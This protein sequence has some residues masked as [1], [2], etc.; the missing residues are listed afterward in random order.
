MENILSPQDLKSLFYFLD[1]NTP[2]EITWLNNYIRKQGYDGYKYVHINGLISFLLQ[3]GL[4]KNSQSW[5]TFADK[6]KKAYRT[7]QTRKGENRKK[8]LNV[9][10]KPS[11]LKHLDTE[12]KKYEFS[13]SQFME[14][15]LNETIQDLMEIQEQ[16]HIDNEKRKNIEEDKRISILA[17][18]IRKKHT[19]INEL[20][21]ELD[22]VN[23]SLE[24]AQETLSYF[25]ETI[26]Q[27]AIINNE[28]DIQEICGLQTHYQNAMS[29]NIKQT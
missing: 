12:R 8:M 22:R 11:L 7:R 27:R 3:S 15:I 23:N 4:P 24:K 18:E 13:R 20:T 5:F 2:S 16:K 29:I 14:M 26:K 1:S 28:Y 6:M 25:F 9:T 19:Q 21:C 10:L 17:Q